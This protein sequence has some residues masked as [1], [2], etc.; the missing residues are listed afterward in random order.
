V[1]RKSWA[2]SGDLTVEGR[3][4]HRDILDQVTRLIAAGRLAPALDERRF[5]L[6]TACDAY[7]II[8]QRRGKR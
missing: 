5:T 6:T 7:C 8:K 2:Y 4:H 1:E 3:R